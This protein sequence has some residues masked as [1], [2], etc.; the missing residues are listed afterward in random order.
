MTTSPTTAPSPGQNAAQNRPPQ[1]QLVEL[2]RDSVREFY[3]IVAP[4]FEE[5]AQAE[6]RD[7]L[8]TVESK[9]E[10]GGVTAQLPLGIG[11]SLNTVLKIPSR[12]LVRMADFGCRDF[13]KLFKKMQNFAWDQWFGDS[14]GVEFHATSKT[15]RLALKKRIEE[16]AADGRKAYR[17]K[18]GASPLAEGAPQV[19]VFI[20]FENDIC[21]VSLDTS[22]ELLHKRGLRPL[23]SDAPLRETIAAALLRLLEVPAP[24]D[25]AGGEAVE[26]VDPMTGAGT[27]LME[28][29]I[30]R[31]VMSQRK[32]AFE[33]L[34]PTLRLEDKQKWLTQSIDVYGSFAG[35]D[36]DAKTLAAAAENL[37]RVSEARKIQLFETDFFE[38]E[39]LPPARRWLIANPPYGERI[40]IE[41]PIGQYYEN[42]FIAAERVVQ[43]ERALFILPEKAHPARLKRPRN[44]RVLTELRFSN[45]GLP[46]IAVVFACARK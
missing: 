11:L 6:L 42:L 8:P 15:S 5:L 36:T 20:R 29:A 17:K 3:F 27:F 46:V 25:E 23:S 21:F 10:R 38:A 32:Y 40:R 14:V 41:G 9:T 28:A 30:L 39:P 31:K 43:P 26:L 37:N 35:F 1:N 33:N 12:I 22:G 18:R 24:L 19:T 16:T 2:T 34:L 45:G 44:W 13:P 7:W 4:G